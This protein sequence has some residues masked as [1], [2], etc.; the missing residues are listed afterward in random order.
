MD[1]E[2]LVVFLS[3]FHPLMKPGAEGE[4]GALIRLWD[5]KENLKYG[6]KHREE[7]NLPKCGF[8]IRLAKDNKLGGLSFV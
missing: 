8:V 7:L 6:N 4:V 3:F 1:E 2:V 5:D